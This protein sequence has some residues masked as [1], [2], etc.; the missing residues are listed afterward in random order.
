MNFA[1]RHISKHWKIL[2]TFVKERQDALAPRPIR[3]LGKIIVKA[4]S[5]I[6]FCLEKSLDKLISIFI[7]FLLVMGT[8]LLALLLTAKVHEES[9]HMIKVTSSLINETVANHP[10]WANWLPE[11]QVIQKA[12][13]SAA[14]N[15]YQYGR[16]WITHKEMP[17]P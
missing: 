16:E 6:I 8:L 17:N 7:I 4:D 2:S 10:E 15:V 11:A 5:K 1:E 13:N 9:V 3:G 14:N 12:L